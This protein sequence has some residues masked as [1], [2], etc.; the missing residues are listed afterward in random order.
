MSTTL[1]SRPPNILH[2]S[3]QDAW[4]DLGTIK[5]GTIK[6]DDTCKNL[7]VQHFHWFFFA[8]TGGTGTR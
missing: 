8:R 4:Y 3:L 5:L 1:K 6:Q 7:S 2:G